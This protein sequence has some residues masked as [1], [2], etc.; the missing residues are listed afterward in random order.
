M[1]GV[2]KRFGATRALEGVTFGVE[3]GQVHALIGENG[4]G[5]STLMK[6]LAGVHA[7]D[8]GS[9]EVDGR[10]Y[11]PTG[12]AAARAAGVAMI[13]QELSI[14]PDLSVE[15]NVLLGRERSRAGFVRRAEQ[16]RIAK[17]AL[18]R[19]SHP[20]LDLRARAGDLP[21]ALQQLVEIARALASEARVLVLDEPTSSLTREDA[22]RLFEV[23][24]D[25]RAHG[26]GLV[27]I[28][29]FLEEVAQVSDVFSVLRDGEVVSSGVM[30]ET[31]LD[32]IVRAM[33]GRELGEMFP[34]VPHVP[35]EPILEV[36]GLTG[37]R[38]PRG[39]DLVVRRG[40][41]LG[42]AGLVGAGRSELVRCI[43]GLDAVRSGSVRVVAVGPVGQAPR[44]SIARGLGFV[45]EDRKGEGLALSLSIEDNLTMTRLEP[46]SRFGW[47][48]LSRRRRSARDWMERVRC[49]ARGPEQSIDALSGG[50][51]QKIAIARLLHQDA[52]VLLLDEPTRG[53]DVGTKAEI[54]RLVGDLAAQGKAIVLVSSY[55]PELMN[56]C[57]RIGVLSRGE[58]RAVKPAGEWTEEDVMRCATASAPIEVRT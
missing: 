25:L 57:D 3:R 20:D 55:L 14:A 43:F 51:Q 36:R 24:R 41:I 56:V 53:I 26:L 13:Y 45:S 37:V 16:R 1:S 9:M 50:N 34:H 21:I 8:A 18:S 11:A 52:D 5:K 29:H 31:T 7:P 28:S 32:A 6:I 44:A 39:V 58:L 22:M 33:V 46:Y 42:L 48:S 35:G 30:S 38:A 47:L 19:L 12:P 54:Y 17:E 23:I 10:P 2:S 15:A 27:Y 49:K 4:A 40:E